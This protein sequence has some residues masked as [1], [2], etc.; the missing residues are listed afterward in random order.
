MWA[1]SVDSKMKKKIEYSSLNKYFTVFNISMITL[2]TAVLSFMII[3]NHKKAVIEFSVSTTEVLAR[4]LNQRIFSDSIFAEVEKYG[5][6][7]S[8]E[9]GSSKHIQ[10]DKI[11]G[12]YLNDYEDIAKFRIFDTLGKIVYSTDPGDLGI[13]SKSGNLKDA[14]IG[15]IAFKLQ[16]RR[17]R[18][19][20]DS[21][22]NGQTDSVDLLLIHIPIYKD[23]YKELNSDIVGAFEISRDV[24]SI[25]QVI[26]KEV[27]T[28]PLKL[29]L[30]IGVFFMFWHKKANKIIRRQNVE[31]ASY[32]SDLKEAQ[33]K[34][35]KSI[36]QVVEHDS[37]NVR[38]QSGQLLKC[39]EFKDCEKKDCPGYKSDNLRCW[40]VAGTFCNG[41]VQGYFANKYGN[42][43]ECEVYQYAFKDNINIIG[44]SFNNM[45]TLLENKHHELG[46]VNQKLNKLIDA[47]PLTQLGN[48][49]SFQKRIEYVHQ[50]S[51]RYRHPY[52]ILVCDVDGFK[53]YNDT[54]GHQKGDNILILIS[55]A[56]RESI[57]KTDGIFRW[58]GEE[59]V[60]ILPE[61]DLSSALNVAEHVRAAVESMG[62]FHE[63][64]ESGVVTVS[65]GVACN[66]FENVK[67]ISWEKVLKQADEEMYRAKSDGR[68][69]VFPSM[70]VENKSNAGI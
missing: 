41:E 43:S 52:S 66:N 29:L 65:I 31:I 18:D 26:E 32:D 62:I 45:M 13:I 20:D 24:E 34:I 37:F 22:E 63:G 46:Q 33:K 61:Q 10:M 55:N 30:S 14:L 38:F 1:T 6:L 28:V 50:A 27:Y 25:L 67:S 58:G 8:I 54:Y 69:R 56:F 19:R 35:I 2:L 17:I 49:R 60:I 5:F 11:A 40:Q 53:I 7:K 64:V 4:Q 23:I 36:N 57:R 9:K 59:F 47:D 44:E 68:N 15:N 3:W 39:W 16:K 42:C 48:R 12:T 70:K 51:L 21:V